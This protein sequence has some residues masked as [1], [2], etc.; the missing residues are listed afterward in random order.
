MRHRERLLIALGACLLAACTG[1]VDTSAS[2]TQG[3]SSAGSTSAAAPVHP[4]ATQE[5]RV[6]ASIYQPV[7]TALA[8]PP[9]EL[10]R[11]AQAARLPQAVAT[12][13][14]GAGRAVFTAVANVRAATQSL[15]DRAAPTQT[16]L[17]AATALRIDCATVGVAVF[18]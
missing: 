14:T 7:L 10:A 16:F 9:A 1:P 2:S 5:C 4:A 6:A 11:I 8:Q 18:S 12:P 13:K 17:D 15:A 3:A